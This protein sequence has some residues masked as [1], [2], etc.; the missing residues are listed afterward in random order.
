MVTRL[1]PTIIGRVA[2]GNAAKAGAHTFQRHFISGG[3]PTLHL[4]QNSHSV[5]LKTTSS[6]FTRKTAK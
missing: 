5:W 2:E 3:D 1:R 4:A 6:S